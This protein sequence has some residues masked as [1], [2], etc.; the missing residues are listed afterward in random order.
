MPL[1]P[2]AALETS[3]GMRA[4]GLIATIQV[5]AADRMRTVRNKCVLTTMSVGDCVPS[6]I[7]PYRTAATVSIAAD[8]PA[9]TRRERL[10]VF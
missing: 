9:I 3:L 1:K 8:S 4:S 7:G 10:L 5:A 6:P 2:P